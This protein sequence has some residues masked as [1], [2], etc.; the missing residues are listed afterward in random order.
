[1]RRNWSELL[2]DSSLTTGN[3]GRLAVFYQQAFECRT[4][5]AQHVSGCRL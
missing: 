1:M 3:I 5:G 4:L 2:H